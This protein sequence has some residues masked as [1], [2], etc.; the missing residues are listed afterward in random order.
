MSKILLK[1]SEILS[2]VK[3]ITEIDRSIH[4]CSLWIKT[5]KQQILNL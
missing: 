5:N 4:N 2:Q 1:M 3:F